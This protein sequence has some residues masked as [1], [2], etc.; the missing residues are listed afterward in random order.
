MNILDYIL[1]VFTYFVFF[2]SCILFA[3]SMYRRIRPYKS[4]IFFSYSHKNKNIA[5]KIIKKLKHLHFR[6]W[7][8]LNL[9]LPANEIESII[10]SILGKNVKQSEIFILLASKSS[11]KSNWVRF[12][13]SKANYRA[14]LAKFQW[15]DIIVIIL[16]DFGLDL[17]ENIIKIHKQKMEEYENEMKETPNRLI[18]EVPLLRHIIGDNLS[19]EATWKRQFTPTVTK[20][21]LRKS[22]FDS[23]V[24]GLENYL[25][26]STVNF[27]L[28]TKLA[29][30]IWLFLGLFLLNSMVIVISGFCIIQGIHF[31]E[32]V[33]MLFWLEVLIKSVNN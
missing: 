22:S 16:D 4:R 28:R 32:F 31:L 8:D 25:R 2:A 6:I 7:I 24:D 11:V 18:D 30:S 13:L 14:N 23:I 9:E 17:Y 15:R 3:G 20:F 5:Q 19:N 33:K 10:K 29:H 21:D 1:H 27:F 12:E 26:N